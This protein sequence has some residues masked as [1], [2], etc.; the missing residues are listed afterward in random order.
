MESMAIYLHFIE[1]MFT[2]SLEQM[3]EP[4]GSLPCCVWRCLSE[5][6]NRAINEAPRTP[7]LPY[8]QSSCVQQVPCP[9]Q[10]KF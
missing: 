8:A 1:L 2:N 4:E 5:H 7:C 10:D 3:V 9:F 6:S